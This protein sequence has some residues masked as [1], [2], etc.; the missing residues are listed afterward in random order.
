MLEASC[1]QQEVE[2]MKCL[3]IKL[4]TLDYANGVHMKLQEEF[5]QVFILKKAPEVI[6]IF[7]SK[8]RLEDKLIYLTPSN[9]DLLYS[10]WSCL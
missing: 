6:G 9:D 2:Y 10:N 8:G 4:S 7:P 5:H 1:L 3:E